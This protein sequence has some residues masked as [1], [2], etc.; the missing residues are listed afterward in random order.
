MGGSDSNEPSDGGTGADSDSIDGATFLSWLKEGFEFLI[1]K[2]KDLLI[3]LFV[4]SDGFLD[5]CLEPVMTV[6]DTIYSYWLFLDEVIHTVFDAITKEYGTP[7]DFVI[8]VWDTKITVVNWDVV[9]PY[10]VYVHS[11]VIAMVYLR[12][13][14]WA[15]RSIAEVIYHK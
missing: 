11:L 8:D 10:R 2:L 1:Q 4:P 9:A 7:P 6:K 5:E 12:F 14:W 15:L 3:F 13:I